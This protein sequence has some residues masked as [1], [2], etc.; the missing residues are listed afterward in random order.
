MQGQGG[1]VLLWIEHGRERMAL[2]GGDG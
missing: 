2:S 1:A